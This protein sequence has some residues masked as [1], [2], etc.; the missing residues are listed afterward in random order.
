MPWKDIEPMEEKQ[1][2][3]H[4]AQSGRFTISELCE[5]F[6]ISRKTGHKWLR[7]YAEARKGVRGSLDNLD[8]L[9]A[10]GVDVSLF[11]EAADRA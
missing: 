5:D 4:L 7:R 2:F 9:T 1:R 6:S 3:I 8:R 10:Q 11:T